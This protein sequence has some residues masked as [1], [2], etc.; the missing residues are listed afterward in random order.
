MGNAK[1]FSLIELLVVIAIVG[2]LAAVG[3]PAYNKYSLKAKVLAAVP[4][5]ENTLNTMKFAFD[6][7]GS[8]PS[9]ITVNGI[10]YISYSS[11][12]WGQSPPLNK[13]N[14]YDFV[15]SKA[16]DGLGAMFQVSLLN[17]NGMPGYTDASTT[18][19]TP[20]GSA[21]RYGVR[22]VNGAMVVVCGAYGGYPTQEIPTE[23]R[24]KGCDCNSV[25]AF[26]SSGT[27]C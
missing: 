18:G 26:S 21:L 9:S 17:L 24:P 8:F 27:G 3:V 15:Y 23:Y 5:I 12:G 20:I 13:A 7:T 10:T 14:I 19:G 11:G 1:G 2:I 25:A 4:V 6:K 16:P 22:Y